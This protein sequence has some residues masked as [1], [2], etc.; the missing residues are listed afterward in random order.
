MQVVRANASNGFA[1]SE[2]GTPR[3]GTHGAR[4]DP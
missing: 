1:H 4:S 3:P 2:A